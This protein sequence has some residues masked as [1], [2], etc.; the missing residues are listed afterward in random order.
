MVKVCTPA[1]LST[2]CLFQGWFPKKIDACWAPKLPLRLP[3]NLKHQ[4]THLTW[5]CLAQ[6]RL[7]SLYW[8]CLMSN[9][10]FYPASWELQRL[11]LGVDKRTMC[12][13][14]DA[15]EEGRSVFLKKLASSSF[16]QE[17]GSYYHVHYML[18]CV[19][20]TKE[21]LEPEGG[22]RRGDAEQWI[23]VSAWLMTEVRVENHLHP[24]KHLNLLN[25]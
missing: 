23:S 18:C 5:L 13:Y 3:K 6:L 7:S 2:W 22:R 17:N 8:L 25:T 21:C 15:L 1:P 10:A 12:S 16:L 4:N 14:W 9:E 24:Q 11:V 20:G 19:S